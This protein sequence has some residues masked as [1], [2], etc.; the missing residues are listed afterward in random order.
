M[1]KGWWIGG[2]SAA[3]Q[4]RIGTL[5][6]CRLQ[7]EVVLSEAAERLEMRT[8][9]TPGTEQKAVSGL[10]RAACAF[11]DLVLDQLFDAHL[12]LVL[13]RQQAGGS[14]SAC[15]GLGYGADLVQERKVFAC[16]E[17]PTCRGDDLVSHGQRVS[18]VVHQILLVT[19][20]RLFPVG[21]HRREMYVFVEGGRE[22]EQKVSNEQEEMQAPAIVLRE[23]GCAC[24]WADA[25]RECRS[26]LHCGR[27]T[28]RSLG[29]IKRRSTVT[30]TVLAMTP[31]LVTMP[32]KTCGIFS[33]LPLQIFYR[34][35]NSIH[36]Y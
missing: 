9:E 26:R 23:H 24:V 17:R 21:K 36:R 8:L 22:E 33:S 3:E 28:L 19:D 34:M 14:C 10:P 6:V 30:V 20:V 32:D 18:F 29:C 16:R 15:L 4:M 25:Q 2:V 11:G 27:L 7:K 12:F 1:G 35:C 31:A 5:A 13:C